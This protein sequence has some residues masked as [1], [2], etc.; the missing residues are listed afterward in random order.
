MF[1]KTLFTEPRFFAA[2]VLVVVFSICLHEF[3]HAWAAL[4]MGDPTAADRGHLTMNPFR[5]MGIVSLI[6]LLIIG[7]AWGQVPVNPYNLNTR[8]KRVIV[9][10]AGVA[11]NLFL[12]FAFSFL[13]VLVMSRLPGQ[14]F[15]VRMLIYGAVIN[16]VLF[17]I[18][19]M[20]VPGFDGF[21]I[22]QEFIHLRIDSQRKAEIANTFFFILAMIFFICIDR[23]SE[24]SAKLVF[25]L[26]QMIITSLGLNQ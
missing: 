23:I 18:N 12:V 9:A 3:L 2:S 5:Q 8:K 6:M 16:M 26:L 20:P 4:K 1:I 10:L 7:I 14:D 13:A 24:F 21:N 22:V 15:A 17:F 25:R 19:I 11:G